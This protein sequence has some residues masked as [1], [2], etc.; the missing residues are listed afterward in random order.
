MDFTEQ[1]RRIQAAQGDPQRLAL[2]T[3]DIVLCSH[4][5]DLRRVVEAAAVPHWFTERVLSALLDEDL[6]RNGRGWFDAVIAL[7]AVEPF[8]ARQGFNVH[9]ATRL[10]V[11]RRLFTE[12]PDRFRRLAA[13]AAAV[14]DSP[15]V[16]EEIERAYHLLLASP[17]TAGP[18][19]RQL[20]LR[21]TG[22]IEDSLALT[23][24]LD[25]YAESDAWPPKARGWAFLLSAL[26]R[27]DHRP[28]SQTA[29]AAASAL[30]AFTAASDEWGRGLASRV[31]GDAAVTAGKLT[32][33]RNRFA[34]ALGI[35]ERLAA[36]DPRNTTWQRDLSVSLNKL[37][38]LASAQG[39]AAG[40]L[41][42]HSERLEITERLAESDPANATWQRDLYVS[43]M[44]LGKLAAAQPDSASALRHFTRAKE[45]S[46][47]LAAGDPACAVWQRDL[48]AALEKLGGACVTLGD[49]AGGLRCF[50]ECL[51]ARE[52]L[53]AAD[54]ANGEGQRDLAVAHYR[55]AG[56]ARKTADEPLFSEQLQR[57]Y[58]VL[59]S[60]KRNAQD[61]DPA[62]AKVYEQLAKRF[63][64][65]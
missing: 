57:C 59:D 61:L 23:R 22:R 1:L 9:E 4:P 38:D 20:N 49:L 14:F 6:R 13:R 54:P 40:A 32:E 47:R 29:Q 8:P 63:N 24:A 50:T 51:G 45:I 18:A 41:K 12:N 62:M 55:L 10:A 36:S 35:A 31:A 53:A 33:A 11:R 19:V 26:N 2:A 52:R 58:C 48:A 44:K 56:F 65:R 5:P 7:A 46:E 42:R 34:E 16:H 3:L 60:M 64:G 15:A 21:L 37:G 17:D 27:R 39:D 28:H 25:E 30:Q 43:H